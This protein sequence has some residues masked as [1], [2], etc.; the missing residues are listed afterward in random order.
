VTDSS[1]T[2]LLLETAPHGDVDSFR[3]SFDA[4]RAPLEPGCYLMS[5]AKGTIIYVGKAK[6]LRSRIRAYLNES[7]SRYSVKFLMRRVTKIEFLVTAT[8]KEALLL[9]NSLIKSHRPRYNVRLKDDKTFISLRLDPREDFPR[10]SVVRRYKKD[11]ARYFGP[12]HQAQVVRKTLR[13][14]QRLFPLRTCSDSVLHN[15]SRPCLY[16]QMKQCLAPCMGL[17]DKAGY[18][19]LVEQVMLTLAGRNAELEARLVVQIETCAASLDFEAA[20]VLRDR[21]Y[22]LRRSLERQRT[23][24]LPGAMDRDVF[25]LYNQGPFTEIQLLFYRGGKMVGG[26]SFS[27]DHG[28]MPLDELLASFV[29]QY[30]STAAV[31]PEEVL[32]PCALEES[33]TLSEILS[34]ERGKRVFLL[35]PQRGEK[36]ALVDMAARNAQRSFR[37]KR[38][39]EKAGVA[40]VEQLQSALDLSTPPQRIECFDISTLQGAHTVGSMVVFEAGRP[41]KK[42]YRRF[43]IKDTEGQ[44]DFACMR[45]VLMRRYT[46]AIKENDLPDLVLIDG[47]K[48]QLGV[49]SAVFS[50]LGIEDLPRVGVAKA[51]AQS[52]GGHSPE[53]FFVP[54]RA[55][56]IVLKQSSGAVR[57]VA[58]IRDEAHR[59]A[60]TYH[61]SLRKKA[62][63]STTLSEI[64][65]LGPKRC[66][67]LLKTLGS[68][69]KIR[70]ASVDAIARTPGMSVTLAERVHR[71][72]E[73]SSAHPKEE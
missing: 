38:M 19:E 15:R 65:G 14:L 61:R 3:R 47:G 50:D 41:A 34:E 64:P 45:E 13:H 27:F 18:H 63:L 44:D 59:F 54:G 68:V 16:Y 12:Y 73:N 1:E 60:I 5:D 70:E 71:H 40:R 4:S 62:T 51:R 67:A 25:G 69:A 55:N 48:G 11:G 58:R 57:L 28:E 66:R 35:H 33:E 30:Y 42:K 26:R 22:D 36:R 39:E 31:V 23:V 17:V 53:R 2:K 49:A 29:F 21:L 9:E 56:P 43:S 32:V 37:E 52:E 46:R 24:D 8:E 20:A 72:F 7:D 6:N 10:V